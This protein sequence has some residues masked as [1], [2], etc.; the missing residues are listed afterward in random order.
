MYSLYFTRLRELREKV[1][2]ETEK[3]SIV[4]HFF[5]RIA[6]APTRYCVVKKCYLI[7]PMLRCMTKSSKIKINGKRTCL[8]FI[9]E[10]FRKASTFRYIDRANHQTIQNKRNGPI[11]TPQNL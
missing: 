3:N 7:M 11:F 4:P 5:Y 8:L 6:I 2:F 1:N 9:N 10:Y